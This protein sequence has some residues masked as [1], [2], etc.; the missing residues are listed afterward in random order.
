MLELYIPRGSREGDKIVLQ[1]EADQVPDQEPGDIIFV[2]K[3]TDHEVF[4]RAGNDLAAD[5][6]VSLAEALTG[7][8]RVVVKHLDGRGISISPPKG[9]ILRP[10]QVLKVVGEGMPLKKSDARGELYMN[11]HVI[12]PDD[13]FFFEKSQMDSI[14]NLLPPAPPPIAAEDVEEVH[15]EEKEDMEDFGAGSDDP[16]APGAHWEDEDEGDGQPQCAQQ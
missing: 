3:E 5:I 2:L 14:R 4:A 9:K 10:G 6:D 12:F 15:Y 1:G 11:V 8:S 7:F 13:D 16:R